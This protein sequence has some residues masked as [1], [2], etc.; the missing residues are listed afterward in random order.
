MTQEKWERAKAIFLSACEMPG[1]ER[2]AFVARESA[3]DAEL[4]S[5]VT[6]LLAAMDAHDESAPPEPSRGLERAGTMIGAYRLVERIGEGGFGTVWSAQQTQPIVRQVAIKLIKPGMDTRQVIARFEQERQSLARMDHPNIARVYDAGATESGRPYFVMELVRGEP[7]LG[8]CNRRRIALRNRLALFAEIARAVQHAHQKGIIHRDLKPSNILVTESDGKPQ[9]KII[10]FGIAKAVS[11]DAPQPTTITAERQMIGTPQYMSPEQAQGGADI[12]TRT[13]VYSLGV[14]L[15]ELLTGFAPI[16]LHHRTS[17]RQEM[18][19]AILD[20]ELKTPSTRLRQESAN[21]LAVS[22]DRSADPSSLKRAIRGELDWIAMKCLE[23]DRRRRYDSAGA[24][25]DDV[26]RHLAGEVI[27]AAPPSRVYRVGKFVRRY[28]TAVYASIALAALL[29][30]GTLL[31]IRD[32]NRERQKTLAA[33]KQA[34]EQRRVATQQAAVAE[35]VSQFQLDMLSAA[36]PEQSFG[37]KVTVLQ[38]IRA[39]IQQLDDNPLRD[40]PLVE[41]SIRY[42][43]GTTLRALG[44]YDEA[45]RNFEKSIALFTTTQP[46]NDRML[47]ESFNGL[48]LNYKLQEKLPEAEESYRRALQIRLRVL[49]PNDPA[50]ATSF[51]NLASVAQDT[52]RLDEAERLYGQALA[53]RRA[54]NNPLR[55]AETINNLASLKFQQRK[56]EEAA[57]LLKEALELRRSALRPDHP[58]IGQSLNNLA[59]AMQAQGKLDETERLLRESLAIRRGGLPAGHPDIAV[60]LQNLGRFLAKQGKLEEAENLLREAYEIRKTK[61][62]L[63]AES[64]IRTASA[65]G[66]LLDK[67]G[68]ADEANALRSENGIAPATRP[69]A[70]Q[71]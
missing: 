2:A 51:N 60:T 14:L 57:T 49:E 67:T 15:Y 9:P 55:A 66:E 10:D 7:I 5:E 52:D 13:D 19:R 56:I 22:A 21:L 62:G 70:S 59:A 69:A 27:Q 35:A 29:V 65:L 39:A 50:I 25:A 45:K 43:I 47:A 18:Q 46:T 32:I 42:Q 30:A 16:E 53:I 34:E 71:P 26:Q 33:L 1:E 11:S 68:R 23:K 61:F 24:L 37:D 6:S 40:Q 41:A 36:D 17:T 44:D 31:Y 64:T 3:G 38:A 48:G 20:T 63:R 12:D 28:R 4:L 54:A 58:M 8:Y